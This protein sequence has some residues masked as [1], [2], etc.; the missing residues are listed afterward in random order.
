MLTNFKSV[1]YTSGKICF[2]AF[3]MGIFLMCSVLGL[4]PVSNVFANLENLRFEWRHPLAIYSLIIFI[5]NSFIGID[6][7]LHGLDTYVQNCVGEGTANI[8]S[9][10]VRSYNSVLTDIIIRLC[11]IIYCKKSIHMLKMIQ[12]LKRNV[13]GISLLTPKKS[14]KEQKLLLKKSYFEKGVLED[15]NGK[16]RDL[17]DLYED[18]INGDYNPWKINMLLGITFVFQ[19]YNI[20]ARSSPAIQG[21]LNLAGVFKFI[22]AG[23]SRLI[24]WIVHSSLA[25]MS[26][27]F[28]FLACITIGGGNYLDLLQIQICTPAPSTGGKFIPGVRCNF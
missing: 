13:S 26:H 9:G 19:L 25:L 8:I 21:T 18:N 7:L 20:Y 17:E 23:P 12:E 6:F 24:A 22:P 10:Y 2:K 11:V 15:G 5:G 27:F 3:I 14:Q 16:A 1:S 28:P 4:F